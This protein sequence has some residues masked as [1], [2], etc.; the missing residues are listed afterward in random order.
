V[1]HLQILR[2]ERK[3]IIVVSEGWILFRDNQGLMS[4]TGGTVPGVPQIVAMRNQ[5][6]PGDGQ[7]DR[8]DARQLRRATRRR[9]SRTHEPLGRQAPPR[10]RSERRCRSVKNPSAL[11]GWM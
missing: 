5:R 3:A 7:P 11:P 10:R 6:A 2:D 4:M 1:R 8:G 9:K